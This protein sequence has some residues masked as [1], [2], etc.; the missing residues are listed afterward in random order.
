MGK[1]EKEKEEKRVLQT[2]KRAKEGE[3]EVSSCEPGWQWKKGPP[4]TAEDG[5]NARRFGGEKESLTSYVEANHIP[6]CA[7][8]RNKGSFSPAHSLSLLLLL[9]FLLFLLLLL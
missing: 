7:V 5:G 4:W 1:K 8:R 3:E 2:E 6:Q 9:S